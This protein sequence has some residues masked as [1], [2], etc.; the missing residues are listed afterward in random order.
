MYKVCFHSKLSVAMG[1]N[2]IPQMS[3]FSPPLVSCMYS[4]PL[5]TTHC[6][7]VMLPSYCCGGIFFNLEGVC[8]WLEQCCFLHYRDSEDK[9]ELRQVKGLKGLKK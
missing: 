5:H 4:L 3:A 9:I 2:Q 6:A 1:T 8:P 7:H